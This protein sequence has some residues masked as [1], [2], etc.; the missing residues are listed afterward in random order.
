MPI[1]KE[2]KAALKRAK[3]L[4]KKIEEALGEL[5]EDENPLLPK[6]L[7]ELNKLKKKI[8]KAQKNPE[9][10]DGDKVKDIVTDLIMFIPKQLPLPKPL[11]KALEVIAKYIGLLLGAAW[12]F[13]QEIAWGRF[14]KCLEGAPKPLTEET[15]RKCAK[16][17]SWD[18]DTERWVLA[19]WKL[20]QLELI[21]KSDKK[22]TK[23]VEK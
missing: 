23:P 10:L 13:A 3:D 18:K 19:Q 20:R 14:E 1:K 15:V 17:S 8:K 12:G 2:D 7:K 5:N 6:W 11:I 16:G 21:E 4:A 9:T 22:E